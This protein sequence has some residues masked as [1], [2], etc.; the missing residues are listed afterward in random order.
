MKKRH[1][2][3]MGLLLGGLGL[4]HALSAP[5]HSQPPAAKPPAAKP[6]A[7]SGPATLEQRL[8][9]KWNMSEGDVRKRLEELGQEVQADLGDGRTTDVPGLGTLRVIRLHLHRE[10]VNGRSVIVD[11]RHTVQLVPVGNLLAVANG[12]GARPAEEILPRDFFYNDQP[13]GL[14]GVDRIRENTVGNAREHR[15]T[16]RPSNKVGGSRRP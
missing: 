16:N 7:P 6:Q 10:T 11:N 8:A 12:P 3:A 2:V 4:I 5:A 15:P 1:W 14:A 13:Y 9:K